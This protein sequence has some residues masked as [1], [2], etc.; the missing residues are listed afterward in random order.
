MNLRMLTSD[1]WQSVAKEFPAAYNRMVH[2]SILREAQNLAHKRR[3]ERERG[4]RFTLV[5]GYSRKRLAELLRWAK[6]VKEESVY[7]L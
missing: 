5:T 7:P 2:L 4:Q 1:D 6:M 3:L